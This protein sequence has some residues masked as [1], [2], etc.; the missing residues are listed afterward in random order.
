MTDDTQRQEHKDTE[1][2]R[3]EVVH[4]LRSILEEVTI[5]AQGRPRELSAQALAAIELFDL[6]GA[7]IELVPGVIIT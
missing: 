5:S 7:R 4:L 1:R 6:L 3:R 2:A